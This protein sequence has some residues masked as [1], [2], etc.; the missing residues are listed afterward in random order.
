MTEALMSLQVISWNIAAVNN[1]PFEYWI[2]HNDA[3]YNQLMA[4]IETFVDEPGPMD[5]PVSDIFTQRM[6][7]D[8][9]QA[10]LS[11]GWTGISE[12]EKQ[13]NDNYKN[14]TIIS[15]FMK[16]KDIGAKRLASMPD[17]I[18]NTINTIDGSTVCRPTVINVY[19]GIMDSVDEWWDQWKSFMFSTSVTVKGK[20][21]VETKKPCQLLEK[22]KSAKYPAITPE[23]EEISVPLQTLCQAIFDATLVHLMNMVAPGTWHGLKLDMCNSLVKQK[24]NIIL[25]ILQKTYADTHVIFLQ[26]VAAMFSEKAASTPLG[27]SHYIVSP[28]KMDGKR[29]QNSMILLSK[30]A[31]KVDT[32]HEITSQVFAAFEEGRESVADGDLLAITVEGANGVKYMLA[33]FHGDTNGLATI[34]VVK[35]V[36][37]VWSKL[38]TPHK[39]VFGLDANTYVTGKPGKVQ[40]V[41]EFAEFFVAAGLTSQWGDSVDVD[42]SRTTLNAR[43]FMQPQ[44]NKAVKMSEKMAKGDHNPKDFILFAKDQHTA[45]SVFKDNTGTREYVEGMVFPTLQFPSDHGIIGAT[46]HA[47]DSSS[48]KSEL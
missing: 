3:G 41:K 44:L 31:F 25:R 32:I 42:I 46:L 1:N 6:F 37:A 33:S 28:E 34:P 48:D 5:V 11:E 36:R 7:D 20:D 9:K 38:D 24:D 14:R 47:A 18:T 39:L 10:M 35:A 43:T 19:E 13:W 27:A 21:G 16:D 23:E 4:G 45:S 15:G 29:D 2:T 22:I 30:S 40:G 8:L 26:E 12:T 17:R